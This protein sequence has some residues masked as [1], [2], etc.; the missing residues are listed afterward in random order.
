MS[1]FIHIAALFSY[2]ESFHMRGQAPAHIRKGVR[3]PTNDAYTFHD[4]V[5]VFGRPYAEGSAEYVRRAA[6]FDNSMLQITALN[7]RANRSWTAGP[8]P[9]MDWTSAER[10]ERLHGY[11]PARSRRQMPLLQKSA[12]TL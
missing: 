2:A 7:S 10:S 12:E 5:R 6:V 8:R 1:L 4:F 9:F 3:E 11:E